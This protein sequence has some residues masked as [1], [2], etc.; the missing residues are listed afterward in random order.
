MSRQLLYYSIYF[1]LLGV[2]L[3]VFR[4]YALAA[5]LSYALF[6]YAS[7][8]YLSLRSIIAKKE[9]ELE[10]LFNRISDGV[11]SLD[12][13]WRYTFL[14]TAARQTH[15]LGKEALGKI[16]WDLYPEMKH[17]LLWDKY[18]EAMRTNQVVE[19]EEFYSP[20]DMWFSIKIYPS[21]EGL[22]IFYKDITESRKAGQKL[23]QTIKEISDYKFALDESS[24]IAITDQKGIIKHANHNFCKISKYTIDELLGQDHRIINSGHH[25][26]EFI[27]ELWTTIANGKIWKGELKNRAKDGTIY[28]VDTTIVPFLNE[29]GKPYQY[30]AIRADITERKQAEENLQKS[31]REI[32]DYK[33]ALDE[34]SIIAITDQKGIIIHVNDNFCKISKYSKQELLGQ[35]HRIINSGHHPK[36]FIRQLWVT[37]ANGKIWK[38]ELKNKAKDGTIYWVDTT[39]VPLLDD[40]GKPHHYL[41][42]RADIT[43]RKQGEAEIIKLNA[44][45]EEKVIQRTVELQAATSEMEAFTYSVS[46]D[47]RA[48]LR[49]IIGFTSILEEDYTSK[50][51]DEAK[52]ITAVIK[53]NTLKMGHLIDDLLDFSRMGKKELVKV[54]IDVELMVNEIIDELKERHDVTWHIQRLPAINADANTIRQ[55]WINLISNAVKYSSHKKHPEIQIGSYTLGD[56]VAFFIRD[57]GVGF[58]EEYKHKLFKVFQRLHDPE[59]F[60]GTGVGLA[61]VEKIVS[62]HGGKV[63]AEGRENEGAC[64]SFSLPD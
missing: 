14:N 39:I 12:R 27:K 6:I 15:A 34:S 53:V 18:Q 51:D 57:N 30:V 40:K 31:L 54:R 22:T 44:E 59:D 21:S 55:V 35:D 45:L 19:I 43:E 60:E 1:V 25:S 47:L 26:K 46:H 33:Y 28:W 38:G 2:A 5:V 10:I 32:A 41:A 56:Q 58:D 61:L 42:I 11:I 36:E 64:F 17:T 49:G 3:L 24:I 63:W 9:S 29:K 62:R 37:I 52:R 23:S 13:N 4:A 50:M 20:T 16:I 7:A 8:R 48:P